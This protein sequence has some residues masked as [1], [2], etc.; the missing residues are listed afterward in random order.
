MERIKSYIFGFDEM[1][2]GGLPKYSNIIIGG[3]PGSGKTTFSL[4]IAFENAK[5]EKKKTILFTTVSEPP[6]KMI[7]F[8][9]EFT[10]FDK[11]LLNT[12][13]IIKDISP[14]I[15]RGAKKEL[16][17]FI[18][19]SIKEH[20]PDLVIIDSFKS[21]SEVLF[22]SHQERKK[23]VYDLTSFL[24]VWQITSLFVGEYFFDDFEHFAE[25]SITDGII[26]LHGTDE[27]SLQK[28]YIQILKLRG[29]GFLKGQQYFEITNKG[30]EIYLRLRPD[31]EKLKYSYI[32]E[33][34]DVPELQ[35]FLPNGLRKQTAT[36]ISGPTGSGKTVLTLKII[37][38]YLQSNPKNKALY[39]GFEEFPGLLLEYCESLNIDLQSFIEDGRLRFLFYSPIEL[40]IDKLAF[41]ISQE[42]DENEDSL[43][44]AIDSISSFR[45]SQRD[46]VRYREFLWGLM[47]QLKF[48]GKTIFFTY[49][50]E[51]LFA[52]EFLA[53]DMKLSLIA[54]NAI[55]LRYKE[56]QGHIKKTI[57]FLKSRGNPTASKIYDYNI[58][59]GKGI[60]IN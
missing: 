33:R 46:D 51:N 37:E 45:Y 32:D 16:L 42:I 39:L 57:T 8:L 19:T 60:E 58:I 31:V 21:L 11:E 13:V 56:D 12:Y 6:Y 30:I 3:A 9:S 53:P 52:L 25:F 17:E 5:K 41:K 18:E 48:T 14:I 10:F 24:S 36:M 1:S 59:V 38:R 54:D 50:I 35:K 2:Y 28:N 43:A 22:E 55:V 29:S 23:Y 4:Q 47:Q 15:K 20:K 26:Y 27:F 40:D 34:F 44:I 49:E 7:R